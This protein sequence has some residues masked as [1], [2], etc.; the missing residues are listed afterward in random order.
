MG[1]PFDHSSASFHALN[2]GKKSILLNLKSKDHLDKLYKLLETSDVLVEGF[3]AGGLAKILKCSLKD[4][5]KR[6]PRLIICSISGYGQTGPLKWKAGHDNN[7]LSRTGVLSMMKKPT[8]LPVQVADVAGGSWPAAF[9]IVAALF[10][11]KNW[12]RF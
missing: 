8:L 7:Y 12:K 3:R 1:A 9:Q 5:L 2:R 4:L 11:V 6:F 10:N